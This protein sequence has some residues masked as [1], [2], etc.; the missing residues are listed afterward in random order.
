VVTTHVQ[1][2]QRRLGAQ[3]LYRDGNQM[4][5]TDAGERVYRWAGETLSRTR[6]LVRELDGLIEGC[7]GRYR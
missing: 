7:A 2:F 4:R 6:E 5:L 3:L 1:S